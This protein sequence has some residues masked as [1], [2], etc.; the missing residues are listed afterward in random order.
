MGG[1]VTRQY[2]DLFGYNDVNKVITV[3]TPHHGISGRVKQVCSVLGSSK[4][5]KDM[6]EGSIFLSRLNSRNIPEGAKFFAISSSGCEMDKGQDG[7][8]IVTAE[9]AKLEGVENFVIEGECTDSLQSNLHTNVL[10]PGFYPQT[11][12]LIVEILKE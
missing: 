7:D 10:D 3:N 11:K 5:C 9:S 4:E 8:G 12:E 1:L 6:S 2:L